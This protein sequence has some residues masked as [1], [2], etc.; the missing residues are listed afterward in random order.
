MAASFSAG[1]KSFR[2]S[3]KFGKNDKKIIQIYC[4]RARLI[5][6][7]NID[8]SLVEN[9][10]NLPNGISNGEDGYLTSIHGNG[11]S[12]INNCFFTRLRLK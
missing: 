1:R 11:T 2:I 6:F 8:N 4:E 9:I 12:N 7:A 3:A 10:L 5:N